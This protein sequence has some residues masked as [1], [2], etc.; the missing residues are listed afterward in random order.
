[1]SSLNLVASARRAA[2]VYGARSARRGHSTS[3]RRIYLCARWDGS[4]SPGEAGRLLLLLLLRLP[5]AKVRDLPK[6]I[7]PFSMPHRPCCLPAWA[8]GLS[9]STATWPPP[10]PH[11]SLHRN[12]A[13]RNGCTHA[14]AFLQHGLRH[15]AEC[16]MQ[17]GCKGGGAGRHPRK[18]VGHAG[19][20]PHAAAEVVVHALHMLC[21]AA[22]CRCGAALASW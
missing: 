8:V 18:Q 13:H 15:A 4:A 5:R 14:F 2:E 9:P 11:P 6:A 7:A 10:D 3:P 19:C 21:G 17:P 22:T 16:I 20:R 1:M 12:I